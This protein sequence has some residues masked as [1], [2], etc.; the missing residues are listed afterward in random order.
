[1]TTNRLIWKTALLLLLLAGSVVYG[2]Q[3]NDDLY[4]SPKKQKEI[5]RQNAKLQAYYDSIWAAQHAAT[6]TQEAN[7]YTE[8][9][10]NFDS[11]DHRGYRGIYE[12]SQKYEPYEGEEERESY[13]NRLRYDDPTYVVYDRDPYWNDPWWNYPYSYPYGSWGISAG[14]WGWSVGWGYPYYGWGGYPYYGWGWGYPYYYGYN[15]YCY[16]GGYPYYPYYPS[17]GG[18]GSSVSRGQRTESMSGTSRGTGYT[19]GRSGYGQ[20]S[21]GNATMSVPNSINYRGT[22]GN[23][24]QGSSG[25][26]SVPQSVQTQTPQQGSSSYRSVRGRNYESNTSPQPTSSYSN[27][28]RSSGSSYNNSNSSGGG[29]APSAPSGGSS[30]GSNRRGGGR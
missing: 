30:G 29:S 13:A 12:L 14:S 6:K 2:V 20:R 11:T 26:N 3:A 9:W 28:S 21:G 15:P 24:Y 7:D 4:F 10:S 16:W 25:S 1:M 19:S 23:A 18:S 5:D 17:G 8:T 27:E 22:R